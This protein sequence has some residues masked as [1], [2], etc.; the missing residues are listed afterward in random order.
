MLIIP[1]FPSCSPDPRALAPLSDAELRA[2][3]LDGEIVSLGDAYLPIDAPAL[4]GDRARSLSALRADTRLFAERRSAAWVHGWCPE[5]A[6][7]SVAVNVAARVPSG[8]RR[9]TGARELVIDDGEL[10]LCGGVH[11]TSPL[12]T[13]LDLAR[14]DEAAVSLEAFTAIVAASRIP[15][16]TV[17]ASLAAARSAPYATRARRRLLAVA[18]AVDVVDRIDAAHGVQH[19]VEVGHVSHLEHELRDRQAV[20]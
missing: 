10:V 12:R 7:A 6:T 16:A 13:L 2:A 8:V 20:A 4:P 14:E 18:D 17:L 1:D 5:P 15:V 3:A 11:V 9:R 19:P